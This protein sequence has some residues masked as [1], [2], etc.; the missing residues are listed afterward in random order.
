MQWVYLIT[1]YK[2]WKPSAGFSSQSVS[3]LFKLACECIQRAVIAKTN[4]ELESSPS[5]SSDK[6]AHRSIIDY[7]KPGIMANSLRRQMAT[8]WLLSNN[9]KEDNWQRKFQA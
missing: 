5:N 3:C 4:N 1:D 6:E 9:E 8:Q 7:E 2:N